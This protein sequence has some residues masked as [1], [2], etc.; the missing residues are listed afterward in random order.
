MRVQTSLGVLVAEPNKAVFF[1]RDASPPC[2]TT[3]AYSA[4]SSDTFTLA[5]TG[6]PTG[7]SLGNVAAVRGLFLEVDGPVQIVINGNSFD[8]VPAEV[9]MSCRFYAELSIFSLQVAASEVGTPVSGRY[10]VWGSGQ[11]A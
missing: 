6:Q 11:G 8:M 5:G 4:A 9:G 2:L 1:E 10:V 3:D 7:L